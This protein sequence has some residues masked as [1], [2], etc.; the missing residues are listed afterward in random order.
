[1]GQEFVKKK[2]RL[3]KGNLHGLLSYKQRKMLFY[4]LAYS[5]GIK[6]HACLFTFVYSCHMAADIRSGLFFGK[7]LYVYV[8]PGLGVESTSKQ[9]C[10]RV[11]LPEFQKKTKSGRTRLGPTSGTPQ[12]P[13]TDGHGNA[14]RMLCKLGRNT[15]CH[16]LKVSKC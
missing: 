12:P 7:T 14:D 10:S 3:G 1:M 4:A 9:R 6:F 8:G 13:D 15:S 5:I 11:P 2:R 16:G